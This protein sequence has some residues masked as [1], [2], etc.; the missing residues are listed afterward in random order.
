[1]VEVAYIY[2]DTWKH[3]YKYGVIFWDWL[4]DINDYAVVVKTI[5][6]TEE[7]DYIKNIPWWKIDEIEKYIKWKLEKLK[8]QIWKN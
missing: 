1:M 7:F 2:D 4:K 6:S 5:I 8:I 3:H